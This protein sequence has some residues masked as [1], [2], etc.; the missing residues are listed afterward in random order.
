MITATHTAPSVE[1]IK[2]ARERLG[3]LARRTPTWKWEGFTVQALTEPGTEVY[4]K[5]E[6]LQ[7][8]GSF[9]TRGAL[10][11]IMNMSDEDLKKGVTAVSAGNHAIAVSYAAKAMNT[12]AKVV[13]P[14][15]TP[16]SRLDTCKS[17]GAEVV[18]AGDVHVAFDLVHSIEKDEGRTLIHPFDGPLITLGTATVGLEL[19]EDVADLDAVIIPVG[20]GG[21]ISG[22]ACAMKQLNPYIQVYGVEPTGADSMHRS[23]NSGK[24]EAIEKVETIA[25]SLGAPHAAEYS[26]D[27][28]MQYTDELVYVDDHQMATTM[29]MMFNEMKLALEPA[30]AA[31]TAALLYPLKEKLAGKKVGVIVCGSNIDVETFHQ[32]IKDH[33]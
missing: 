21:L 23:F 8:A 25:S 4:F 3:T 11:S 12:S 28:T 1:E 27:I 5:L 16:K 33:A 9:K 2:E 14:E 30:A 6:M 10:L 32:A 20:G 19:F 18:L 7:H 26:L 29:N 17:L 31:A 22:I 13:M 24:P 15:T